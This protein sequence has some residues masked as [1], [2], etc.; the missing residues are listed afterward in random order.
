MVFAAGDSYATSDDFKPRTDKKYITYCGNLAS[1]SI[2]EALQ[3]LKD[4]GWVKIPQADKDRD[5]RIMV[6]DKDIMTGQ[7]WY[8]RFMKGLWQPPEQ[9]RMKQ[10]DDGESRDRFFRV[11]GQLFM[12]HN[13]V[14]AAKKAVGIE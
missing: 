14:E 7:E 4:A 11:G 2:E 5:N 8:D 12:Y 10:G 6:D 1:K 13:A 3:A 9:E